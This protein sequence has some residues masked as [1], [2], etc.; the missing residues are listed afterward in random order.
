MPI[1]KIPVELGSTVYE[2]VPKCIPA[3][4]ECPFNG[5]YGKSRCDAGQCNAYIRETKFD[6][7]MYDEWNKTVFLTKEKAQILLAKYKES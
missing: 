4:W 5:G 7:K 2:V 6:L 1:I 3:F